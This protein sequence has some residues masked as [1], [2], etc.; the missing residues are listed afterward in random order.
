MDISFLLSKEPQIQTAGA[1]FTMHAVKCPLICISI[2][3][4]P[5]SF[6]MPYSE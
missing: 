6:K 3:Q 4:F 2:A 5:E 1:L